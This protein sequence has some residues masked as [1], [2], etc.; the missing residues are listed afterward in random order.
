MG[1][2]DNL[3]TGYLKKI[4]QSRAKERTAN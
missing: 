3:G 1:Q 2:M 4:E